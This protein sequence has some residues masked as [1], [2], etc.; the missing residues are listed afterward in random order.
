MRNSLADEPGFVCSMD[1]YVRDGQPDP[2]IAVVAAR[3]LLPVDDYKI[4]FGRGRGML[5]HCDNVFF[6]QPVVFAYIEL[7]FPQADDDSVHLF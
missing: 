4:S 3:M 1:A 5:A 2:H 6:I 7:F